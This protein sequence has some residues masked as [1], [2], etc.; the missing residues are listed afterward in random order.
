MTQA[1]VFDD[2]FQ[3]VGGIGYFQVCQSVLLF[4]IG[5]FGPEP[6]YVNFVAAE[7][8]H[9]CKVTGVAGRVPFEEQKNVAIPSDST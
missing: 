7:L 6:V 1:L 3:F 5:V 4:M 8:P 9:W 2:L